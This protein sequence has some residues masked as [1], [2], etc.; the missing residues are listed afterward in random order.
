MQ[1]KAGVGWQYNQKDYLS[2]PSNTPPSPPERD[3][4]HNVYSAFW[5]LNLFKNLA[6]ITKAE[7]GDYQSQLDT[8][9]Y[10]QTVTS[11]ALK[12]NF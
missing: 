6:V 7:Y 11:M 2:V 8:N 10:T 1:N 5:H 12:V 9:T 4:K 3:A